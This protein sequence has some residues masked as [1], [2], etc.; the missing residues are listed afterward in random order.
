MTIQ[1][2]IEVVERGEL[3][4]PGNEHWLASMPRNTWE[5]IVKANSGSLDAAKALHDALLPGWGWETGVNAT[6]SSIAQVW[7]SGRDRAST[8]T[9][10]NPARSWLLAILRAVE[11]NISDAE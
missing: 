4:R 5:H 10:E 1:R 3:T 11:N 6:F 2:L 9:A 7:K 8:A